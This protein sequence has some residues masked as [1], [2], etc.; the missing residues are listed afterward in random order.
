MTTT[1]VLHLRYST[2]RGQETYGYP[3]VSLRDETTGQRKTTTGGGYD[4]TGT[5]F[6]AW[7]ADNAQAQLLAM[8]GRAHAVFSVADGYRSG[9]GDLYGMTYFPEQGRVSLDGACGLDSMVKIA[10][11]IGADVTRTHDRKGNTT[12]WLVTLPA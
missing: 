12:G 8:A 11:T 7:L 1:H 4:L 3:L 10:R 9:V 5:V 6:G 2:S